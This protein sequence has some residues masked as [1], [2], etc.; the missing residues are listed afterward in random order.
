M[1]GRAVTILSFGCSRKVAV[2]TIEAVAAGT[3]SRL[4]TVNRV[5]VTPDA[6]NEP[7]R[8]LSGP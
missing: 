5:R 4:R 7:I 3:S 6:L 2:V 1:R 8:R